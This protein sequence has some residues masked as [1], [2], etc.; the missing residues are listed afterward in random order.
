MANDEEDRWDLDATPIQISAAAI[1]RLSDVWDEIARRTGEGEGI[2]IEEVF[3]RIWDDGDT[4]EAFEKELSNWADQPKG[5]Q[6]LGIL[7]ALFITTAYAGQ[8]MRAQVDGDMQK[9]WFYTRRCSYWLGVVVGSWSVR[10][11]MESSKTAFAKLG[12]AARH[13]ENRAMKREVQDWLD[14]NMTNFRS[15]DKAAEAIAGK[16]SPVS[17]RTAR[18]WVGEWKKLRS[19]GKT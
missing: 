5:V 8:A 17:F 2:F 3:G 7:Q 6:S 16:V 9:A 1:S 10:S 13:A 4:G 11:N 15:M 18:D 12:A 19:P 14:A